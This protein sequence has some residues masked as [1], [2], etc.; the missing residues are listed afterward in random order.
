MASLGS[1]MEGSWKVPLGTR[2]ECRQR[3]GRRALAQL[4]AGRP[5]VR[6]CVCVCACVRVCVCVCV[7]CGVEM[8][9]VCVFYRR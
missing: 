3:G 9:Y 7:I 2:G 8:R 4:A 5:C 1:F 6:V